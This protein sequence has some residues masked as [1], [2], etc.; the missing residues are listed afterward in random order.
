MSRA[1]ATESAD[2]ELSADNI[3]AIEQRHLLFSHIKY[4]VNWINKTLLILSSD[5]NKLME[6]TVNVKLTCG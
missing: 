3:G 2:S 1:H 4:R 5:V 6:L